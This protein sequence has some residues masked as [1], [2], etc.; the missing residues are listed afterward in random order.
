MNEQR[1]SGMGSVLA[2]V[3]AASTMVLSPG[4]SGE[5]VRLTGDALAAAVNDK[6]YTGK[7]SRGGTWESRYASDGSFDVR[8]LDSD[9]SD[10]GTWA[11]EE[12][13]VCSERSRRSCPSTWSST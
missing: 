13:R 11:I 7:T 2:L 10:S 9:W 12:D 6:M 4:A 8:V 1:V 5:G 3:L